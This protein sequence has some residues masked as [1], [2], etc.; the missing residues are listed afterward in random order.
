MQVE[1]QHREYEKWK[2]EVKAKHDFDIVFA[3]WLFDNS[4]DI[5][6]LFHSSK[7]QPPSGD[8]FVSYQ[9]PKV[10]SLLQKFSTT[11]NHEVRRR[12]NYELHEIL[13]AGMPLYLPLDPGKERGHR[14]QGEEGRG[15]SLPL[16]HLHQ[17]LVHT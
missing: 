6:S 7:N 13:A 14:E 4:S 16:L 15:A 17:R 5:S 9:N 12:I 3:E 8:N 11:I 10:D 2:E 1:L